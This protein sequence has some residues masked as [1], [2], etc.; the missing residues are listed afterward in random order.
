MR[1]RKNK[2]LRVI[3]EIAGRIQLFPVEYF[4]DII[5]K[6]YR[7]FGSAA[8]LDFYLNAW[9]FTDVTKE[10]KAVQNKAL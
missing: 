3:C 9:H 6:Y 10:Q 1:R 5:L 7:H 8:D 4:P 2:R